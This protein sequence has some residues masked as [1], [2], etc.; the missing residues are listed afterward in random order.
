MQTKEISDL[1]LA[2]LS[3]VEGHSYLNIEIY[4]ILKTKDVDN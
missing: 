2:N 3:L 1:N 4:E